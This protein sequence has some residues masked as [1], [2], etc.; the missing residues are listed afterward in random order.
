MPP[1]SKFKSN[2]GILS[3]Y[4]VPKKMFNTLLRILDEDEE[5]KNELIAL[6]QS[7]TSNNNY[8]ENAI[9]FKKQ[10][11]E[12][13]NITPRSNLQKSDIADTQS[14]V[15]PNTLSRTISFRPLQS[16]VQRSD[17]LPT[18]VSSEITLPENE[19]PYPHK[20]R[21]TTKRKSVTLSTSTP[22]KRTKSQVSFRNTPILDAIQNTNSKGFHV[23]PFEDCKKQYNSTKALGTHFVNKHKDDLAVRKRDS[24]RVKSFK[25][26]KKTPSPFRPGGKT[27]SPITLGG[28]PFSTPSAEGTDSLKDTS[29]RK[30]L[31][32]K[33][34]PKL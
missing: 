25:I 10:Q 30:N 27:P 20:K 24:M 8:I 21:S 23:C 29:P 1:I 28:T 26:T 11:N 3:M 33:G 7:Q 17:T 9:A 4:L 32:K 16:S 22:V 6:N 18:N 2:D 12:Q 19:T 14:A 5:N 31:F 15:S 13:K 34:Y